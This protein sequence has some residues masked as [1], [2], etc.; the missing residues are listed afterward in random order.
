L[1][2]KLGIAIHLIIIFKIPNKFLNA[3][4]QLY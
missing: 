1:V 3:H 4:F 2:I